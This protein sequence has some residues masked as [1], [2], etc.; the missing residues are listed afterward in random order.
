MTRYFSVKHKKM[1]KFKKIQR[2]KKE[3]LSVVSHLLF[4]NTK[5]IL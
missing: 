5:V 2:S 1:W 4:N 3:I